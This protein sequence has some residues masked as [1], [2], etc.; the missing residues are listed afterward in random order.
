MICF[1]YR[2]LG[3]ASFWPI[4]L[5]VFLNKHKRRFLQMSFN[6]VWSGSAIGPTESLIVWRN[7]MIVHIVSY[8]C[9]MRDA[10]KVNYFA[11]GK[12]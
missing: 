12:G 9:Y 1:I 4:T 6:Q 7:I 3:E 5:T 11:A 10:F 2:K 8:G